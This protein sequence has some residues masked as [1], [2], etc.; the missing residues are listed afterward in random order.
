VGK[1]K[2]PLL[3]LITKKLGTIKL[4][5]DCGLKRIIKKSCLIW[6]VAAVVAGNC[7]EKEGVPVNIARA[8]S[9][10]KD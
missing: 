9:R 10:S 4:C 7:R 3:R 6:K 8:K 1:K 5:V 2:I